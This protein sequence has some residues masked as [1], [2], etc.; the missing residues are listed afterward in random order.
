MQYT[1][2]KMNKIVIPK[3]KLKEKVGSG[4]FSE[5][6]ISKAQQSIDENEVDFQPIAD[7]YLTQI[8]QSLKE[9]N[10]KKDSELLYSTLLDQLTQLR[11]QGSMFHYP[12]ITVI[13][14]IVVD[15]LDSLKRVDEKIV[16]IVNAYEQAA[17]LLLM[18]N[19]KKAEGGMC[20]A[21]SAE[22]ETV[23][24]KYKKKYS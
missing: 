12:S 23:C 10:E 17:K 20:A 14:D 2:I 22:L 18:K 1:G 6:S 24:K 13:T 9:Y 5:A 21:I 15:L 8:R 3:N 7:T 4:G 11:A 19:V 16:E